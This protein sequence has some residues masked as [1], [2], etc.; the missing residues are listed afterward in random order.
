MS[1]IEQLKV[2][3]HQ[4][5]G[6]AKQAAGGMAAFKVKFSQHVDQVDS[7]IRGTATGADRNIA[8][9]LGAAG[10]AVENAAAA[11]EMAAAAARQYADQ[12]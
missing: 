2:Q 7:L 9:I 3:L 1:Q 5:A 10:A 8:E 11:L 4:I 6:E 12:V